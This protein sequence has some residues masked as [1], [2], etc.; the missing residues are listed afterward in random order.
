MTEREQQILQLIKQDPLI[1]QNDLAEKLGLSRSAVASHIMNLTRKGYI[2]GKGYVIA[3]ERFAA[4]VGGAN[5]DLC[6]RSLQSLQVG[7]SNPGILTSGPGGVARN[8]ADNLGR[9]GSNVQ[10]IGAVGDDTWG[11]NLL[12]SCRDVGV[13]VDHCF[14]MPNRTTST[15]LSIHDADGEMQLALNDMALIDELDQSKLA[16]RAQVFNRAG[17]IVLD[18]NLPESALEYLFHAHSDKAIFVDPVSGLKAHKI[19]PYLAHIH[20]LKPNLAEAEFLSG[21]TIDADDK[22]DQV[23]NA[24]HEQGVKQLLI[25]LGAKGAYSS[26]EGQGRFI[27]APRT[28]VTNVTGAGDALMAG[29]VHGFLNHWNWDQS[30]EFALAAARLTLSASTTIN[31]IMSEQ[32]VFRLIEESSC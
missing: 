4:V 14:V 7:D 22:L 31:S 3:P 8:I 6:G 17:V 9:M 13:N 16:K 21:I 28:Q 25:S 5:M 11:L 24:L 12:D 20:T 26:V 27:P 30:V 18:A 19:K 32:A 2:Q 15:Y 29:L 23:A 10:F 1:A